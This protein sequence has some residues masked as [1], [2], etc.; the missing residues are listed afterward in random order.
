MAGSLSTGVPISRH[1]LMCLQAPDPAWPTARQ[2]CLSFKLRI[3]ALTVIALTCLGLVLGS[4]FV[5]TRNTGYVMNVANYPIYLLSGLAVPL[6]ILPVWTRPLS[7]ALALAW[8]NLVLN[9]TAGSLPGS[10]ANSFLWLVGLAIVYILIALGLYKRV[11]YRA[12]KAGNLEM[13]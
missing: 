9:Q 6:T 8:G 12:R 5:L 7:A 3:A 1:F 10:A 11:E 13:W 4:L 2:K